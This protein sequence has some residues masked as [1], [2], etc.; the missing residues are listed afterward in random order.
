M[1]SDAKLHRLAKQ[2]STE[3][4]KLQAVCECNIREWDEHCGENTRYKS[5]L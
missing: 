2:Q 3:T 1:T 4:D 5:P